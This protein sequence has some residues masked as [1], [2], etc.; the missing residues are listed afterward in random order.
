MTN[1]QKH[2][3]YWNR[4]AIDDLEAIQ[5]LMMGK[6]Y[7]QALFFTHLTIEKLLKALWVKNNLENVPPKTHNLTYLYEASSISL[8]EEDEVF[9]Q[10]LTT[11]QIEGRYPDYISNL[12]RSITKEK[13]EEIISKAKIL[14]TCLQKMMQ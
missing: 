12:Y 1:K 3:E 6:K 7:L 5:F 8:S 14:V 9:L 2:I 10:T 11:F 13:A 4:S